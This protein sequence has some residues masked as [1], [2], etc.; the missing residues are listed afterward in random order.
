MIA[1]PACVTACAVPYTPDKTHLLPSQLSLKL[2]DVYSSFHI[3]R[4]RSASSLGINHPRRQQQ[5]HDLFTHRPLIPTSTLTRA[6]PPSHPASA[7][8]SSLQQGVCRSP[9]GSIFLQH[10]SSTSTEPKYSPQ[11]LRHALDAML[12]WPYL[13]HNNRHSIRHDG[14]Q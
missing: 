2:P 11:L 3:R 13:N 8:N 12:H 10:S 7:S 9:V 1:L 4:P 14:R 5:V 6:I